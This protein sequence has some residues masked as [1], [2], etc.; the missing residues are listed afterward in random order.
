MDEQCIDRPWLNDIREDDFNVLTEVTVA[1]F[2]K[3]ARSLTQD[4][5]IGADGLHPHSLALLSDI[6]VDR[7][8]R[9]FTLIERSVI[10]PSRLSHVWYF[11]IPKLHGGLRPIGLLPTMVRVWERLWKPILDVDVWPFTRL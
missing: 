4:T 1:D 2:R 8:L 6:G 5:G 10:W 3:T 7:I 9:M 11:L